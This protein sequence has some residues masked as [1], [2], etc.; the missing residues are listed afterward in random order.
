MILIDNMTWSRS[1][2]FPYMMAIYL[3]YSIVSSFSVYYVG[4]YSKIFIVLLLFITAFAVRDKVFSNFT[5]ARIFFIGWC[6]VF[7]MATVINASW[8]SKPQILSFLFCTFFLSLNNETQ[9]KIFRKYVWL[10]ALLVLL[11]AVEYI[12]FSLFRKGFV[13]TTVTRVQPQGDTNFYHLLFNVIAQSLVPRFQGLFKEPGNLGTTCAFMLF[14]TWKDKS[15][16]WPFYIFLICGMLSL[17][18]GYYVFLAIF[19]LTSI[20]PN[21]KNVFIL[22]MLSLPV[23]YM[24]GD[25]FERR[26]IERIN[27]ASSL[28][29]LDN[30]TTYSFDRAFKEAYENGDLWMGVGSRNMPDSISVDGGNAGAKKWIFQY[31]IISGIIVFYFY[32]LVY[33]LRARRKFEYYDLVFLL[34]FW[35]CFYKSVVFTTP[36]LFIIYCIMPLLNKTEDITTEEVTTSND[37][38]TNTDDSN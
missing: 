30:R 2:M 23:L 14:A 29:D 10:L 16:K 36:S 33:F 15:L 11:S 38:S 31:G 35:I 26:I 24:F 1:Y 5:Q 19:V 4:T 37:I 32:Y 8:P 27:N 22:I 21:V 28:S 7:F 20:K 34:V 6:I 9:L 13:L 25:S 17:S 18:L 3:V 12:A